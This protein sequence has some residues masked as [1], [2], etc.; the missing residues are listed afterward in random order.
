M[1]IYFLLLTLLAFSVSVKADLASE[2]DD[3]IGYTIVERKTI[4]AWYEDDEFE[5]G[6]FEGC[7]YGRTIIFTGNRVI[8]CA[9]YGYQYAYRP[10]AIILSN[11]MRYKMV[12][13]D[14][15]YDMRRWKHCSYS[16]MQHNC[17]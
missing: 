4:K 15:I 5:E 6:S 7:N 2:L 13:G 11:G 14:Q 16:I 17:N 10:T 9:G 8:T 12:V 1:K 3:L